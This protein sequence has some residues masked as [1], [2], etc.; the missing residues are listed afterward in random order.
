[1]D[2][3]LS[4]CSMQIADMIR[5]VLDSYTQAIPAVL[6]IPSKDNPYDASKDSILRRAKVSAC[7][8]LFIQRSVNEKCPV[9]CSCCIL[10]TDYSLL[11]TSSAS[12]NIEQ[13]KHILQNYHCW[14]FS[15]NVLQWRY[16]MRVLSSGA[17]LY[18]KCTSDLPEYQILYIRVISSVN[19]CNTFTNINSILNKELKG[20]LYNQLLYFKCIFSLIH[21]TWSLF[22]NIRLARGILIFFRVRTFG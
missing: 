15:G 5:H 4:V 7:G 3:K 9:T 21:N 10:V 8:L 6:E 1:M 2:N 19:P 22:M 18:Y 11:I 17:Y 13:F 12:F 14:H 20:R 16:E